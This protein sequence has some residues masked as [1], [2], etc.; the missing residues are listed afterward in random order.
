MKMMMMMMGR[1]REEK[2]LQLLD[3]LA[4]YE[5]LC[6]V[7]KK[8]RKDRRKT[9]KWGMT[10]RL[11]NSFPPASL[12]LRV[13]SRVPTLSDVGR[14]RGSWWGE[15]FTPWYANTTE[16][17][18]AA[19]RLATRAAAIRPLTFPLSLHPPLIRLLFCRHGCLIR[20]LWIDHQRTGRA[21]G[22]QAQ[23]AR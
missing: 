3:N 21:P 16:T 15:R 13:S 1:R 12:F 8:K 20:L 14:K 19:L 7:K 22:G 6:Y 10:T 18:M 2:P 5:T 17:N 9:E 23:L 4:S 11:W